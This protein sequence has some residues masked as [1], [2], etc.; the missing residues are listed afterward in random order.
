MKWLWSAKPHAIAIS[1][2]G[3]GEETSRSRAF[4]TRSC[5][6][7]CVIMLKASSRALAGLGAKSSRWD[8]SRMKEIGD[9]PTIDRRMA[10]GSWVLSGAASL[11]YDSQL[12][13]ERKTA[14]VSSFKQLD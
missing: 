13:G 5:M 4:S 10:S 9:A 12:T 7:N 1:A 8:R 14:Q 6:K 3:S 2:I 11:S